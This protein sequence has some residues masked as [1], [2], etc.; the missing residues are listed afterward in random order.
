MARTVTLY[1][2]HGHYDVGTVAQGV[3]RVRR[4]IAEYKREIRLSNYYKAHYNLGVIYEER[5]RHQ[6]AMDEYKAAIRLHPTLADAH[7]NLGRIY[8]RRGQYD[9]AIKEYLRAARL[10]RREPLY[11]INLGIA[12]VKSG[13]RRRAIRHFRRALRLDPK[14]VD[15]MVNLG[16]VLIDRPGSI[17]EGIEVLKKALR[18]LPRGPFVLAGLAIGYLRLGKV[19]LAKRLAR[20]AVRLAPK[21]AFVTKHTRRIIAAKK[22]T[23]AAG[24][25]RARGS[26]SQVALSLVM[27]D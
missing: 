4:A 9:K 20:R 19:A 26:L 13:E 5:G 24:A 27:G 8:S 21:D 2:R 14:N 18:V 3:G 15:A 22:L 12:L 6:A 17:S 11:P 16:F 1:G 25:A 10:D 7:N 23:S